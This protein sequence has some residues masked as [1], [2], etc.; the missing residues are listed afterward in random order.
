MHFLQFSNHSIVQSSEPILIDACIVCLFARLYCVI[1]TL[2]FILFFFCYFNG[3]SHTVAHFKRTLIYSIHWLTPSIRL[4]S[5]HFAIVP[6]ISNRTHSQSLCLY[7][8]S[9]QSINQNLSTKFSLITTIKRRKITSIKHIFYS[10]SNYLI[11]N[12]NMKGIKNE[13]NKKVT[14]LKYQSILH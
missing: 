6:N 14:E 5:I 10:I 2:P 11:K 13:R 7:L 8:R 3:T 9:N 12:E 1:F 4:F